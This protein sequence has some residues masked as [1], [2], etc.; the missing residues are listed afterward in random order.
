MLI[1]RNLRSRVERLAPFLYGDA[2]PY[3]VIADGRLKWVMDLYTITDRYPYSAPAQHRP[4][5]CRSPGFPNHFNYIRNSVKAVVD[6]YDG[7]MTSTS[8]TPTIR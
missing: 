5:E 3:L 4:P 7:T 8:S 6:A 2:D 1:E